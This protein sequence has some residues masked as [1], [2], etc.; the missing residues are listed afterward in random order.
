MKTP[1]F[2]KLLLLLALGFRLIRAAKKSIPSP[3]KPPLKLTEGP[4][5]GW[6]KKPPLELP[7]KE[8]VK[9]LYRKEVRSLHWDQMTVAQQG[10]WLL[11][12]WSSQ[13]ESAFRWLW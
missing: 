3:N 1:L 7:A 9:W 12:A 10:V 11:N 2:F 5:K 13:R 6:G 8:Q 4:L